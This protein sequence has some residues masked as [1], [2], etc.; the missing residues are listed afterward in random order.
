[1]EIPKKV[2]CLICQNEMNEMKSLPGQAT[3]LSTL[4]G[5]VNGKRV[6]VQTIIYNCTNCGNIQS[7]LKLEKA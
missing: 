1:M 6:P 5:V 3:N 7:F 2:K 4:S